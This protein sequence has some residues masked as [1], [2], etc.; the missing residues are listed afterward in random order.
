M[1]AE[2]K[3]PESGLVESIDQLENLIK[4][5][6]RG[7][8]YKGYYPVRKEMKHLLHSMNSSN[9]IEIRNLSLRNFHRIVRL[10]YSSPWESCLGDS[11]L[12]FI[13]TKTSDL[14][15]VGV[16]RLDIEL[17]GSDLLRELW[18]LNSIINTI[19]TSNLKH[20]V[21]G[22][23]SQDL[24]VAIEKTFFS[25]RSV[26]KEQWIKDSIMPFEILPL[27]VHLLST[28][29]IG[30][31]ESLIELIS[32]VL[33]DN[34][35]PEQIAFAAMDARKLAPEGDHRFID[36]ITASAISL[37]EKQEHT[38]AEISHSVGHL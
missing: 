8:N 5:R 21:D 23:F 18:E 32:G 25:L 20:K 37:I 7:S 16:S 6:F 26:Q 28:L 24:T 22:R 36:Q 10:A 31:Q 3:Q 35:N 27:S 9:P 38:P 29:R 11:F 33:S 2:P 4:T 15:S 34:F 1:A 13:R 14:A 19:R 17:S 12:K 30:H